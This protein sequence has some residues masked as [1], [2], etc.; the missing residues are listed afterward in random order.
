MI[1]IKTFEGFEQNYTYECSGS[2]KPTFKTKADF[3]EYMNSNGFKKST[4]NKKTDMLIVQY[5][6]QGTLKEIKAQKY[7]IPIYTYRESKGKIKD[8]A[9]EMEKYNM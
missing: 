9:E 2:P 3:N 8:M 1:H 7:G 6:G 4:L 5:K